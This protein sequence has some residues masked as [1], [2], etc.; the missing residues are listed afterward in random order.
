MQT[1]ECHRHNDRDTET[2]KDTDVEADAHVQRQRQVGRERQ[3]YTEM[4]GEPGV[5]KA[6][7][8]TETHR[9]RDTYRDRVI[10]RT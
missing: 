4:H 3:T 1:A 6:T 2:D 9:G 8:Q 10:S 5:E 7:V